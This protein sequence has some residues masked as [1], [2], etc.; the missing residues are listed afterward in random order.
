MCQWEA[1]E[2]PNFLKLKEIFKDK[3]NNLE[4]NLD[5]KE[6]V[7][8]LIDRCMKLDVDVQAIEFED[9]LAS[10]DEDELNFETKIKENE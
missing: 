1:L 3:D 6:Y 7:D 8:S 5:N 2:R 4:T 10:D 9:D